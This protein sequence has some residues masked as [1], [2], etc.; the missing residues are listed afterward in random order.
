LPAACLLTAQPVPSILQTFLVLL[1]Q[2]LK[3]VQPFCEQ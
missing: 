1:S 3:V 2:Q